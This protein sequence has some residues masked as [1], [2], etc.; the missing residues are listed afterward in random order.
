MKRLNSLVLS[1]V[2]NG[3]EHR[4]IV[5]VVHSLQAIHSVSKF[6][7]KCDIIV[8]LQNTWRG[9]IELVFL[10][11][12]RSYLK[13]WQQDVADAFG[14]LLV[15]IQERFTN[16]FFLF[17]PNTFLHI[18]GAMA[19]LHA[20]D[21]GSSVQLVTFAS[22]RVGGKNSMCS[23]RRYFIASSWGDDPVPG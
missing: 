2:G 13:F 15:D 3:L 20:M 23:G 6:Q 5:L 1:R 17:L 14:A 11:I 18:G 21:V 12:V 4:I 9:D 8:S 22:P 7:S 10:N 19:N 16:T